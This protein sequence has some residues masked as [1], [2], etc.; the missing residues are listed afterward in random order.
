MAV[1]GVPTEYVGLTTQQL[2][3]YYGIAIGGSVAPSN[4]TVPSFS[5]GLLGP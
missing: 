4:A 1:E 3:N 5:N 2:W